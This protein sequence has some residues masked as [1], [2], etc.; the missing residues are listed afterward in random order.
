MTTAAELPP[1]R[2]SQHCWLV[3]ASPS[4]SSES[5]PK[6]PVLSTKERRR[7]RRP[8]R[9]RN[10]NNCDDK[11]NSD[12]DDTHNVGEQSENV[13]NV[14]VMPNTPVMMAQALVLAPSAPPRPVLPPS[15]LLALEPAKTPAG[16]P[17][18]FPHPCI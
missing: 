10:D 12:Y 7:P 15:L 8:R 9:L 5:F 17:R 6:T 3:L 1:S 11:S 13:Y 2:Q 4:S 14:N 18:A 16:M